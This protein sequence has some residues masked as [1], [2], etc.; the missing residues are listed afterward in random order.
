MSKVANRDRCTR[1]DAKWKQRG[2]GLDQS[3][4]TRRAVGLKMEILG[5]L[6]K[7]HRKRFLGMTS[8]QAGIVAAMAIL[9]CLI[10]GAMG[11]VVFNS[12]THQSA[13]TISPEVAPQPTNTP[14]LPPTLTPLEER[15]VQQFGEI[16]LDLSDAILTG[17][18]LMTCAQDDPSLILDSEWQIQLAVSLA[19]TKAC[20][21]RFRDLQAPS[22]F[23]SCHE[24]ILRAADNYDLSADLIAEGIGE[25][26]IAK[27]E[28]STALEDSAYIQL[29]NGIECIG[30]LKP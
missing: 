1:S 8:L 24:S 15:Y 7:L 29:N 10:L 3:E 12:Q 4:A 27:I 23:R 21:Q 25:L 30:R 26:D 5:T 9:N 19:A 20:D 6:V 11:T 2:V 22:R 18:D 17:A 28:R 13:R 16:L 14:K